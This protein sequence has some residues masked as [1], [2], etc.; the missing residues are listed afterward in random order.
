MARFSRSTGIR[1]TEAAA[2][3]A[4]DT[5]YLI[6]YYPVPGSNR[7]EHIEVVADSP[8]EAAA[9]VG[10]RIRAITVVV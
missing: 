1:Y 7:T 4:P 3:S 2:P 6:T 10:C 5:T 8:A 9:I